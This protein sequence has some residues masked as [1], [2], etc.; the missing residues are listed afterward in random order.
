ME[1]ND[2]AQQAEAVKKIYAFVLDQMKAGKEKSEIVD[3]LVEMQIES[4]QARDFV[5]NI[6]AKVAE[7]RE[8]EKPDNNTVLLAV[9]GGL[10]AAICGGIIWGIVAITS[11]REIGILAWGIGLLTGYAVVFITGGKK[12][13]ICRLSPPGQAFSVL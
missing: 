13:K 8:R 11:N 1:T 6:H 2:A 5:E 3:N 10:A 4:G 7:Q 12:E 9:L